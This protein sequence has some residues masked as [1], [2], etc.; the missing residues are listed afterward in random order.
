MDKDECR[1][2]G[3]GVAKSAPA[4]A[5]IAVIDV[6]DPEEDDLDDL[7]GNIVFLARLPR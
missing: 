3:L 7:D 2:S 1:E 6:P 5:P 4:T